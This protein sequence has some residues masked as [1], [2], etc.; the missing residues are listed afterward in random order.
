MWCPSAELALGLGAKLAAAC[1]ERGVV[2]AAPEAIKSLMLKLVEQ[3][4]S[5]EQAGDLEAILPSGSSKRETKE[6][7]RLR[8][9]LIRRSDMADALVP[10]LELWRR[11]YLIMDEVDVLL[12]PLRSEL[13]FP[14]GHK[15]KTSPTPP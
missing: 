10:I 15:V 5:I 9:A 12:H 4:H 8:D 7:V 6:T 13:N 1:R 2:V 3:L 11:S 14:I